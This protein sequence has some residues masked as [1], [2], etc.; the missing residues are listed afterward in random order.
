MRCTDCGNDTPTS[1]RFCIH[2][3][4]PV[5]AECTH[6]GTAVPRGARFCAHCGRPHSGAAEPTPASLHED[7]AERRPITAMFCDLVDSTE[8]SQRLDPEDLRSAVRAYQ[9]A[10]A[11]VVERFGGRVAQYLGDGLL[12][13]FGYPVA[14]EDDPIRAVDAALGMMA[15]LP[16][17]NAS[18]SERLPALGLHPLEVRVA[19][20][21][22]SVVVGEMGA[23]ERL[24]NL[25]MGDAVIVAARLETLAHPGEILIS[26]TTR[27]LLAD[28]FLIEERGEHRLKGLAEPV[29]AFCVRTALGR[30]GRRKLGGQRDLTPFVGRTQEV[31]LLLDRCD[32]V[33]SGRGRA[34]L[35]AAEAG[36][37][38]SRLLRVLREHALGRGFAWLEAHCSAYHSGT[39]FHPIIELL[40]DAIGE[41]AGGR[42]ATPVDRLRWELDEADI[43]PD[44]LPLFARLLSLPEK[45]EPEPPALSPDA[46]RARTLEALITWLLT[47]AQGQPLVLAV[48]DLHWADPSTLELLG[49]ALERIAKHPILLALTSRPSR[50]LTLGDSSSIARLSL[51]PLT[52][53]Q[54]L[55]M[56]RHIAAAHPLP[57]AVEERVVE[58][59]DGVPLFVEELTKTMA[60]PGTDGR[61][62]SARE[63]VIPS[64]LHASL[65]AR[66]DRLGPAKTLAQVA[67][68]IGRGFSEELLRAVTRREE[69]DLDSSLG[70]LIEADLIEEEG[71]AGT[72]R[73]GFRHALIQNAAYQSLLRST[74]RAYHARIA[75]LLEEEFPEQA[76]GEP[77]VIARH[78]EEAGLPEPAIGRYEEAGR[79]AVARSANLEAIGHL[80]RG[81]DLTRGLPPSPERDA[82]ELVLLVDLG[83]PLV[84]VK[85]Y[86]SPE[87]GEVYA[88]ARE[89]C[90]TVGDAPQVFRALCGTS[91]FFESRGEL[92]TALE[93]SGHLVSAAT[94]R[95][96]DGQMIQALLA[97]GM[98]FYWMGAWRT[99]REAFG[100]AVALHD[101]ER[102]AHLTVDFGLDPGVATRV[103]GARAAWC[104]GEADQAKRWSE[105]A[106]ELGRA[107]GHP[108]SLGYALGFGATVHL[109]RREPAACMTLADEAIDLA[110]T[111]RFPL[112]EWV[113]RVARGWAAAASGRV[114]EG[115]AEVD[116][117]AALLGTTGLLVGGPMVWAMIAEVRELA[118]RVDAALEAVD[119]GLQLGRRRG[120]HYWDP[121]LRRIEAE[122][123]E[124]TDVA[125]A[126]RLLREA[127]QLAEAQDAPALALRSASSLARVLQRRGARGEG[128]ELLRPRY[129]RLSEGLDT[130]DAVEARLLLDDGA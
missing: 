69:L 30:P 26:G 1:S 108:Y 61:G 96:D 49:L 89:L 21:T 111:Q 72:R 52:R 2:C 64:T 91:A 16:T 18:L 87:V 118:G 117:G 19:I 11:P 29:T 125:L 67:A 34:I 84:A 32:Q 46:E 101:P 123:R 121:E 41:D 42:G 20:S 66:L 13:Y 124:T 36:M 50:T 15:I 14:H 106:L 56:I 59:T 112:I 99:A 98:A 88:R 83:V 73:Y 40:Q 93:L 75:R 4:T 97:R 43:D 94:E 62:G 90:G 114:E 109:L 54:S 107:D 105:R 38:K 130:P 82:R 6:C 33:L 113:T 128:Q 44:A 48:E 127:L 102:H 17:V 71:G 65:L 28:A 7:N 70:Q 78:Y 5:N 63:F 60:V 12:V 10:C 51:L 110:Q 47:R 95:S 126:E 86:A 8:L 53:Q 76:Q 55:S 35:I 103:F 23:G 39:S 85:G 37:G 81:I 92:D 80:R 116:Q 100:S 120:Q 77:E 58:T 74:R 57:A 24:E 3:G 9:A 115:L 129:E 22:G 31:D 45:R 79:S 27:A 104:L 25:A 122:L 119:Q 68:V